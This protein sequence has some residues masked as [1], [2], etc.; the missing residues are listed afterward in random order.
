MIGYYLAIGLG[1]L[2]SLLPYQALYAFSD[3]L[4][5]LMNRIIAYRKEVILDNLKRSFPDKSHHEL[6]SIRKKFYRNFGD[7]IVESLKSL[8]LSE[9]QMRK[10]VKLNKREVFE[11]LYEKNKGVIM[12][13][14]H[15][16]NFEW[17]ATAIPLLAPQKCFAVYHPLSNKRF[18]N[19]IVQ[20]REQ[21]G[22]KLFPMAE[23]Y[24]FMLENPEKNPLYVFMADQ[25]PHKGKIK[26]RTQFLNQTTP[27]HLGVE[28]LAKKCNLAVVFIDIQRV[29][30]G[31]YEITPELLF[32]NP[33]EASQYEITDTHVKA[34]EK[35]IIKKP[36]DW[37]WSHRRWKYA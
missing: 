13:M 19:K 15:Y 34:L 25:S 24:P 36:S 12:V 30:R 3:F 5:F 29:K 8:N 33:L 4:S 26:Y 22:L 14:G 7:I 23:T 10:R 35:V 28:N 11:Q 1:Y 20:I 2:L 18:S 21:F 6:E 17:I 9:K 37:L 32:E 31:H 16:T 27:V